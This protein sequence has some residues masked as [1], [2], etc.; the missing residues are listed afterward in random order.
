MGGGDM[1]VWAEMGEEEMALFLEEAQELIQE[2]ELGLLG[3]EEADGHPPR[4]AVDALFRA[5]HTLK[6]SAG[7]VGLQAVE[8]LTHAMEAAL[9]RL[10]DGAPL[11]GHLLGTLLESVDELR[12]LLAA[13]QQGETE[14]EGRWRELVERLSATPQPQLEAAR[15]PSQPASLEQ[16]EAGSASDWEIR[17]RIAEDCPMPGVRLYQI[18]VLLEE[19]GTI[20]SSTPSR[21]ELE[22]GVDSHQ[23]VVRWRGAGQAEALEE[24]VSSVGDVAEVS[25]GRW[26][27]P[28]PS[29]DRAE[30]AAARR[31]SASAEVQSVRLPVESLDQLLNLVGELVL[32]R[33]QLA[34]VQ[35]LLA[36]NDGVDRA[37]EALSRI[38]GHLSKVTDQLQEQVLRA[39]LLPL[40]TVFRQY[41]RVVRD[42]AASRGKRVRLIIEGEDTRVDRSILQRIDDPL[43]HL[44]RNAVDHGIESPEVRIRA[45]KPQE[46]T[47][48]L[49]AAQQDDRVVIEVRDDGGGIDV[50]KVRDRAVSRGLLSEAQAQAMGEDEL[51]QMIF[52]PGFST[53]EVADTVSG[54]GVGLDV[55]QREVS[56]LNGAVEVTSA[57]GRGTRFT[58]KLPLTMGI[59]KGLSV[60]V[61]GQCCILPMSGVAE[62]IRLDSRCLLGTGKGQILSHRDELLPVFILADALGWG[63]RDGRGGV[64]GRPAVLIQVEDRKM[65]VVVDEVRGEQEVVIK[66]LPAS[67]RRSRVLLG[68][69]IGA[70][71]RVAL[72]LDVPALAAIAWRR[73]D[74]DGQDPRRG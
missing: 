70:D 2:M 56:A 27:E 3:L 19:R 31:R 67:L 39:R 36:E 51:M 8:G 47:V 69:T 54:R 15:A 42:L 48:V 60:L 35:R 50:N 23:L 10:R 32:D 21:S 62:V 55:V 20:V 26:T 43:M 45:G 13:F 33:N 46:G 52:A 59:I 74:G 4:E 18:A 14:P 7:M 68:A 12:Q 38:L 66:Q 44:L 63:E 53:R 65:A 64:G 16:P 73:G 9:D 61:D 24:A 37:R 49:S 6:G 22:E 11:T 28:A 17:V 25:V 57:P 71:G 41:P 72:I 58:I 29:S 1:G 34:D 5:A 30:R 40:R